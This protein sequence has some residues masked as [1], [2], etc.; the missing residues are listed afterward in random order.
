MG[1]TNLK[2]K[3]Y[4]NER[5]CASSLMVKISWQEE[6]IPFSSFN[7]PITKKQGVNTHSKAKNCEKKG[8]A[9]A[10]AYDNEFLSCLRTFLKDYG[11][12]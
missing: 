12:F 6:I 1:Q 2:K 7:M 3:I 8:H 4:R 11:S 9:T 10:E 5:I